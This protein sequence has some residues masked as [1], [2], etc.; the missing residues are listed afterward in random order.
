MFNQ[1]AGAIDS[2]TFTSFLVLAVV[3]FTLSCSERSSPTAPGPAHQGSGA[4]TG[5]VFSGETMCPIPN[6]Q[7]EIIAGG[8]KGSMARQVLSILCDEEWASYW[9]R[10]LEVNE[11]I[12]IRASADGFI[13]EERDV[14]VGNPYAAA[15]FILKL[16]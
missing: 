2:R 9:L 6:A 11:L 5:V 8:G 14:H 13:A 12:R 16:D 3:L 7:V 15:T 10:N 1:D 4:I